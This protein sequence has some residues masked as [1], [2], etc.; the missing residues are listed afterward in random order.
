MPLEFAPAEGDLAGD[1]GLTAGPRPAML[2]RISF[3]ESH[4]GASFK[5]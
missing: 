1:A 5:V 4:C 2:A 3:A